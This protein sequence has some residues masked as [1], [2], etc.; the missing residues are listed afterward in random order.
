ME[1]RQKR[2]FELQEICKQ[3]SLTCTIG[4]TNYKACE[5]VA[6]RLGTMLIE[7][8][9]IEKEGYIPTKSSDEQFNSEIATAINDIN[10][11]GTDYNIH[12]NPLAMS[13]SEVVSY[14]DGGYSVECSIYNRHMARF[15][16]YDKDIFT[17]KLGG[18]LSTTDKNFWIDVVTAMFQQPSKFK[19]LDVYGSTLLDAPG[20]YKTAWYMEHGFKFIASGSYY[21][22]RNNYQ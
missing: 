2:I 16:I 1:T 9:I 12:C 13:P 17:F 7:Y 15:K 3:Q 8:G 19:V 5:N 10:A 21:H 6:Q 11:I 22:I 18:V 14:L 20:Q 4:S